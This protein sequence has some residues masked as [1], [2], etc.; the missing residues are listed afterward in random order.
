MDD[1]RGVSLMSSHALITWSS[2]KLTPPDRSKTGT[3]DTLEC[4]ERDS[5]TAEPQ[6]R[7]LMG[8]VCLCVL[9]Y[10][11]WVDI[12]SSADESLQVQDVVCVRL[13]WDASTG[14]EA[15]RRTVHLRRQKQ[16]RLRTW[17]YNSSVL[18]NVECMDRISLGLSLAS[19]K[20]YMPVLLFNQLLCYRKKHLEN[21][22][23]SFHQ[24]DSLIEDYTGHCCAGLYSPPG[25]KVH[26]W[27]KKQLWWRTSPQFFLW[28]FEWLLISSWCAWGEQHFPLQGK[29]V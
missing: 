3:P 18:Y 25:N 13:W 26:S 19:S 6:Q 11:E 20:V 2:F 17:V 23:L 5:I 12:Q 27:N 21:E 29:L 1:S 10:H 9:A 16:H 14:Q 22:M 15:L 4:W 24:G 28:L 7:R 8:Y